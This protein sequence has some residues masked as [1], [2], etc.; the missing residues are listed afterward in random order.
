M[1]GELEMALR[2][3]EKMEPAAVDTAAQLIFDLGA[4]KR[5][6]E[7]R[8]ESCG[9]SKRCRE[10]IAVCRGEC[11]RWHFPKT[12]NRVDFFIAVFH[13][14]A[15]ATSALV[16]QVRPTDDRPYQC[17]LLRK[18]GCIFAFESRPVV[19]TSAF[20]CL[21]GTDYWRYKER[22]RKDI[23]AI[24]AALSCLIDKTATGLR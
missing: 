8:A 17:P 24:R 18:D 4:I 21:A 5:Q 22:F 3:R 13:L 6:I 9:Y 16:E 7:D 11:C 14:A 10:A 20:P 15:D 2:A 12:I 1:T 23:D 19:C